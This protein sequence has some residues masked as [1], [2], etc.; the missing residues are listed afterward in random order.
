[1]EGPIIQGM[2]RPNKDGRRGWKSG[3]HLLQALRSAFLGS[4]GEEG[5]R[6]CWQA[7]SPLWWWWWFCKI[8]FF[9]FLE[10]VYLAFWEC[11]PG[12]TQVI[13]VRGSASKRQARST[14]YGQ[15]MFQYFTDFVSYISLVGKCISS[16]SKVHGWVG[17]EAVLASG[18]QGWP[19][20][21]ACSCARAVSPPHSQG[22][23]LPCFSLSDPRIADLLP[24]SG[25]ISSRILRTSGTAQY[26][27]FLASPF[28]LAK[29]DQHVS[30]STQAHIILIIA[31]QTNVNPP[32]N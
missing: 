11:I 15:I 32:Y 23:H 25:Q 19:I 30:T 5:K 17:L 22:R 7:A 10:N 31:H 1:M 9:S 18:K 13:R 27:S 24:Q 12:S 26:V 4:T 16:V 28:W 20:M 2:I 29:S 8:Y 6:R 14:H 21:G 3:A